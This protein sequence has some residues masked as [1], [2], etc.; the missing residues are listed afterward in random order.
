MNWK[1]S[2]ANS[3]SKSTRMLISKIYVNKVHFEYCHFNLFSHT[4]ES[5]FI[6]PNHLEMELIPTNSFGHRLFEEN[7]LG[8]QMIP[9]ENF[10][11]HLFSTT[12]LW[13]P[14]IIGKILVTVVKFSCLS[15]L[16]CLSLVSMTVSSSFCSSTYRRFSRYPGIWSKL[17]SP[18]SFSFWF[19][20]CFRFVKVFVRS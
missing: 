6:C 19:D 17:Y 1:E 18:L 10:V 12:S 16:P 7:C 8:K 14:V 2:L 5:N 15:W 11:G 4:Y 20:Y 13:F 3:R 9:T